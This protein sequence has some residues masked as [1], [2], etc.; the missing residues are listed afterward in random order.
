MVKKIAFQSFGSSICGGGFNL[1]AFIEGS[2]N[3]MIYAVTGVVKPS[4]LYWVY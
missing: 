1:R 3:Y 4:N 2:A